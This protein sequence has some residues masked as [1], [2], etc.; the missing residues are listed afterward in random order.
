M[1]PSLPRFQK[2]WSLMPSGSQK[3]SVEPR[4]SP[5]ASASASSSAFELSADAD[6]GAWGAT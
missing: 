5:F 6:F 4:K 2:S 3:P 1:V